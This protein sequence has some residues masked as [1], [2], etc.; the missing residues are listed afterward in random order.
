M[1]PGRPIMTKWNLKLKKNYIRTST[2]Q[3]LRCKAK[4]ILQAPQE[5]IYKTLMKEITKE[6]CEKYFIFIDAWELDCEESRAP[7]NWCF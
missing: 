2:N 3:I 7:K 1:L 6:P 4:K 5:E